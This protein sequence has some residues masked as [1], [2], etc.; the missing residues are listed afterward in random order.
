[1]ILIDSTRAKGNRLRVKAMIPGG[2]D[3]LAI[4]GK[5]LEWVKDKQYQ[6]TN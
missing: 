3:T 2:I 5:G 6:N 1:M 4:T